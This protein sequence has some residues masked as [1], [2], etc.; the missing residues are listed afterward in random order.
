MADDV[1]RTRAGRGG[2]RLIEKKPP[3]G[4]EFR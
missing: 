4:P 3:K 1:T 2:G